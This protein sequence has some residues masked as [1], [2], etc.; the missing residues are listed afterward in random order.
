MT[1]PKLCKNCKYCRPDWM[2]KIISFGFESK[3]QFAK[4]TRPISG[5]LVSGTVKNNNFCICERASHY[6]LDICG[7]EGKY[8]EEK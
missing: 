3:Y 1:E 5:D 8:F 6:V 7:K 2:T 4:C